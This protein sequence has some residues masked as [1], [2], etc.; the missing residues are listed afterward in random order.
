MRGCLEWMEGGARPRG[1]TGA[2]IE[3]QHG[4]GRATLDA[5]NAVCAGC[6]GA[7]AGGCKDGMEGGRDEDGWRRDGWQGGMD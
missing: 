7:D 5:A 6:A 2:E 4:P 1:G 3:R